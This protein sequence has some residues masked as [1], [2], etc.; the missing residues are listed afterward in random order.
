[1]RMKM[2]CLICGVCGGKNPTCRPEDV[3]A[4]PDVSND[5]RHAGVKHLTQSA[6]RERAKKHYQHPNGGS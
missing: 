2:L 4:V 1:M 5:N 6:R 3:V